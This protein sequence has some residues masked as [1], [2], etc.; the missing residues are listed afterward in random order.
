MAKHQT[1]FDKTFRNQ[2]GEVVLFEKPN[3]VI[4]IA[5][6]AWLVQYFIYIGLVHTIARIIFLVGLSIWAVLEVGWGTNYFR[7]GLG[8]VVILF[9]IWEIARQFIFH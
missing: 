5:L 7:R 4:L 8:L 1:L 3:L 6:M 2:Q 9:L